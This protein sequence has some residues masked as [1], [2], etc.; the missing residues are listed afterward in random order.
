MLA[1]ARQMAE[2]GQSQ[3]K[4]M[5]YEKGY[6][7]SLNLFAR[8]YYRHGN[9][10][11]SIYYSS[12][13]LKLAQQI[14][15]SVLQSSS[16]IALGSANAYIGNNNK[17]IDYYFK[18]LAI[19]EKIKQQDNL[20]WYFNNIGNVFSTMKDYRK[21]LEYT[22]KAKELVEKSKEKDFLC[23]VYNNIGW[24]YILLEK[25]DSA[26]YALE[27]SLKMAEDQKDS[28]TMALCLDNLSQL[29]IKLKKYDD[30]YLYSQRS[31]EISKIQGLKEQTISSLIAM[32]TIQTQRNKFT[33]AENDLTNAIKMAKRINSKALATDAS[34]QMALLYHK[35][36][37]FKQAYSFYKIY[38]EIKD[39]LLNEENSKLIAEMNTKYTT[40]KKEKE[41]ELLKKNEDIQNLELSKKKNELEKQ[42]TVSISI[43]SGFLLLMIVAILLFS[44]YRLKKKANDQLQTAFNL[45]EEK[46]AM[47]EKSN[48]M[49]TDSITY[50]KRI[51]DAI[52]PAGEDLNRFFPDNFFIFYQP[53]QI[54]SGDF[55][56][57]SSQQNKIIFVVADCTGHGV[58]GA[59][60]SMIGNTLLNEIVNERKVTD[61]KEIAE[62]MN[63]KIIQALHQHEGSQKYDG[64]DI[65]IC[66]IDKTKMEIS[67]TGAN[68]S[69]Y[70]ITS[71][72]QK[73]KGD[74]Y[75][76]GG[77]QHQ[78][79]KNFSSKIIPYE[80]GLQL[81]LL[82]DGY[83]DQ[84][85]GDSNKRF[86]SK[87]LE[88]LLSEIQPLTMNEQKV[89]LENA[90]HNWKGDY[91]QRDDVLV[92]GIRC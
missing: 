42:R 50:A 92:V 45:I 66:C 59:F 10:D 13:A 68:H 1:E 89:K 36:K 27:K 56:W 18:G 46:N 38:S 30:A 72:L 57:C 58:P 21:A 37:K 63:E 5:G 87:K 31:Y 14:N 54:V 61:T 25:H 65:S 60:M 8:I 62:L 51:Q 73:I 78:N 49:I 84:S 55:Y 75:S 88:Q 24:I 41:I 86:S 76:I 74:P 53:S 3:S 52:L 15:D 82:T 44:S 6:I 19:E 23:M 32:G 91:K 35:Q 77:A 64:M 48:E 67:Y 85:G 4:K 39:S 28:Y 22:L 17:A 43:F 11:S 12:T 33:Q 2:I 71:N 79:I 7:M 40:E 16:L 69:M 81:Y 26:R 34:L 29:Y 70:I 9:Y 47:I 80:N 20:R 90:F 83:C